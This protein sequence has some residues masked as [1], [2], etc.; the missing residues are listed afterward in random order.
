MG[1]LLLKVYQP[2]SEIKRA[3]TCCHAICSNELM[4]SASIP[5][6]R[7]HNQ[8]YRPLTEIVGTRG[9]GPGGREG[10]RYAAMPAKRCGSAF[11]C[12]QPLD[13]DHLLLAM[14]AICR[15]QAGQK[16]DHGLKI[17]GSLANVG[18]KEGTPDNTFPGTADHTSAFANTSVEESGE[19]CWRGLFAPFF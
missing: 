6:D 1:N 8:T 16:S 9:A 12:C 10:V 2:R 5:L 7:R 17:A 3:P 14:N 11:R 18:S 15:C 19:P 13:S 4:R